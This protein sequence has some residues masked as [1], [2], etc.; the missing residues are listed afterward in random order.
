MTAFE[1]YCYC[2]VSKNNGTE[3]PVFTGNTTSPNFEHDEPFK[4]FWFVM[5]S[6]SR[7]PWKLHVEEKDSLMGV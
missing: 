3:E 1:L 5:Q 2:G 4:Q 6:M 7:M